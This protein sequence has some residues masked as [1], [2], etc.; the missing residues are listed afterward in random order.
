MIAKSRKRANRMG[1]LLQLVAV[2]AA[3]DRIRPI[4]VLV[5]KGDMCI[6]DDRLLRSRQNKVEMLDWVSEVIKNTDMMEHVPE[7]R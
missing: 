3:S 6:E 5:V 1:F 4:D 2:D 7:L